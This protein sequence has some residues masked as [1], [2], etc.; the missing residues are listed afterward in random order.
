[1]SEQDLQDTLLAVRCQLGE[2]DAW[3]KLVERWNPRLWRFTSRMLTDQAT[4]EDVLQTVWMRVVRSMVRL[5]DPERLAAWLYRIARLAI[6]D[7]L[8]GQYRRPVAYTVEDV[9]NVA[10]SDEGIELVDVTD[11]I[12]TGLTHLHPTDRE[13]VVLH[14][15]EQRPIGEVA[16]ICGVPV[17]TVKSRLHRARRVLRETL[18]NED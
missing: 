8:R 16:E 13:A 18:V 2:I 3:E 9:E 1:M 6:A 12:E 7:Q 14:Y 15:L 4:A 10:E 17:G 5:Q 11:A